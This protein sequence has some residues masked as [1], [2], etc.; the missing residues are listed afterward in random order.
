MS[1]LQ[2]NVWCHGDELCIYLVVWES[3]HENFSFNPVIYPVM[4][5]YLTDGGVG[6]SYL[7]TH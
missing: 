5:L 3:L 1:C 2:G 6:V 7:F 4:I